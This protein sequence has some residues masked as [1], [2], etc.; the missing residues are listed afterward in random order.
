M[1]VEVYSA[2]AVTAASGA[3]GALVLTVVRSPLPAVEYAMGWIRLGFLLLAL[4]L[5]SA[6]LLTAP[7]QAAHQALLVGGTLSAVAV[8]NHGV[9]LLIGEA[10]RPARVQLRL[11]LVALG[12]GTASFWG[13]AGYAHLVTVGLLLLALDLVWCMRK[14]VAKARTPASW[15]LSAMVLSLVLSVFLRAGLAMAYDGPAHTD[16]LWVHEPWR[17]VFALNYG[18]LPMVMAA[19]LLAYGNERL[20]DKLTE[21]AHADPLTG[22]LTRR[23]LMNRA[24]AIWA[25][26]Q[27]QSSSIAVM[28]L[29][30]DHFKAINDSQGH[31]AGDRVLVH[32]VQRL[33]TQLRAEALLC[34]YGGEEFV[35]VTP[36][37]S[38]RSGR[39]VAE[40]LR[41]AVESADWTQALAKGKRV[42]ASIGVAVASA[43]LGIEDAIAQADQ[44][45]YRAK[46]DG[47]NQVQVALQAA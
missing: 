19:G 34:R 18:L 9:A 32:T 14:F 42:T 47:R 16:V 7:T 5:G 24:P 46:H 22:A 38:L 13:I 40:R 21:Q 43:E 35:I 27:R 4:G 23:A 6:L 15:V 41:E 25:A 45:L 3:I 1:Q 31:A 2:Y 10:V 39:L 36:V 33:R 37:D 11:L 17:S 29:D 20:A 8:S 28:L 44:A 12:L 30:L 26:A